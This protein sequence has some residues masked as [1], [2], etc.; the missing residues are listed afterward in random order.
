VF[1]VGDADFQKKCLSKMSDLGRKGHTL[2][3]V[4]HDLGMVEQ[5]CTEALLLDGGRVAAHSR[6]VAGVVHA[7]L[8]RQGSGTA[9]EW[10]NPGNE[11]AEDSFKPLR[12]AV[13][14]AD[15]VT[16]SRAARRDEQVIFEVEADIAD[17]DPHLRVG[18]AVYAE[19]G[20]LLYWSEHCDGAVAEWPTLATGRNL[21]RAELPCG[22]LN[23]GSY[24]ISLLAGLDE[25][26]WLVHP[27]AGAPSITLDV[28][29]GFGDSPRWTGRRPGLIAPLVRW[30]RAAVPAC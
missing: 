22:L 1:A 24:R 11:F 27:G 30:T 10:R 13:T 4:S 3:F 20:E 8:T 14:D 28:C 16:L 17:Y 25:G 2:V 19:T 7:Y 12:I 26:D 18:Y 9:V 21:L 15:G 5:L 6:D 29:G 23:E